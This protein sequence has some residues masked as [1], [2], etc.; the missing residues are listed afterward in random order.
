MLTA[1][2]QHWTDLIAQERAL[3]V[4]QAALR[5]RN[6]LPRGTILHGPVGVGKSSTAVLMARALL[7][8]DPNEPLGCGKCESCECILQSG[9]SAHP[10]IDLTNAGANPSVET[11][12]MLLGFGNEKPQR[13]ATRVV[14]IDE[15]QHLTFEAWNAFQRTLDRQTNSYFIFVC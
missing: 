7:C 15:A 8:T 11:M 10:D 4:L 5:N 13:G 6:L 9:Y 12:Q 1:T 2:P 14:I 3:T